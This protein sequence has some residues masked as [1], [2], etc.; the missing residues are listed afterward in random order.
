M[1]R[2]EKEQIIA[3]VKGKIERAKGMYFADF[4]GITVEEVNE[5]RREFRKANVDYQVVKNTL[6]RKALESATGYDK[7]IGRLDM[8][9]AIAFGYDDPI[10]PARIIKKFREKNEKLKVK[11]CVVEKQVFEGSQLD[12]LAKLP[13]RK[14]LIAGILATI[15]SPAAGIVGAIGALMRDLVNIV[16]AIEKKKAA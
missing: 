11:V 13:N 8:P 7:V 6:A 10:A 15:D 12:Q 9:T 1:N 3:E 4:T 5:L 14:E 2:S 16:D